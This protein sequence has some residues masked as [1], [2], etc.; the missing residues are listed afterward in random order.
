MPQWGPLSPRHGRGQ[1]RAVTF[2][3]G[4]AHCGGNW[5]SQRAK[6]ACPPAHFKALLWGY[7]PQINLFLTNTLAANPL[8]T[9]AA[10]APVPSK[11]FS[12][13]LLR[14]GVENPKFSAPG[15]SAVGLFL[16]AR[17][18]KP[19]PTP[20]TTFPQGRDILDPNLPSW[21]V[22]VLGG[23]QLCRGRGWRR[24]QGRGGCRLQAAPDFPGRPVGCQS[25][26]EK[27]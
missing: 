27:P 14:Y 13:L 23:S 21:S 2:S 19:P 12:L 20:R 24:G 16:A 5:G 3:P 26:R 22:R 25:L 7:N 1:P 8:R 15:L 17:P 9:P 18:H 10:P 4:E 6:P 11:P